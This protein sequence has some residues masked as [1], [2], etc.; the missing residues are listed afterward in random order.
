MTQAEQFDLKFVLAKL[1]RHAR[2]R[3]RYLGCADLLWNP[4]LELVR[5]ITRS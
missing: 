1:Q 5:A 4:E 3:G 2:P